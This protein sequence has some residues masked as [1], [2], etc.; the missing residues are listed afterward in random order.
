[1]PEPWEN[2]IPYE[3]T[4]V[5]I[6]LPSPSAGRR[7]G[8]LSVLGSILYVGKKSQNLL[9]AGWEIISCWEGFYCKRIH[10]FD[11]CFPVTAVFI[12]NPE[13]HTLSQTEWLVLLAMIWKS[14][15]SICRS[16]WHLIKI[17]MF[18]D[19]N[20][21]SCC[22]NWWYGWRCHFYGESVEIREWYCHVP[23]SFEFWSPL[24]S[25][26][27]FLDVGRL[28]ITENIL[29]DPRCSRLRRRWILFQTV[30]LDMITKRTLV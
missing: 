5:F 17:L 9:W 12:T 18:V 3:L 24:S 28:E 11:I 25:N 20:L 15:L 21:Y 4:V 16:L 19:K 6:A 7:Q 23:L 30:C 14:S 27:L 29:S 10:D 8:T 26:H 13:F 1:M 22:F 2:L